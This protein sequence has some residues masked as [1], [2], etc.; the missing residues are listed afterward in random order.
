MH[1]PHTASAGN[2]GES[3]VPCYAP[4]VSSPP[5]PR[6]ETTQRIV[7]TGFMGS[8]KTTVGRLLAEQLGWQFADLDNRIE[9]GEGRTVPAIFAEQGEAAF[10]AAE[11]R[12]LREV[13]ALD[14][15][16][17][18]LGGGAAGTEANRHLLQRAAGTTIMHL[19]APFSVLFARCEAQARKP[20]A[21]ARPLLGEQAAAEQRYA[22]REPWYSALAHHQV[23]AGDAP[24]KVV[25]AILTLITPPLQSTK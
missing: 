12:A 20:G 16:V 7:L 15:V 6:R 19:D 24:E 9:V 4:P 1:L 23:K 21:T 22:Q 14:R 13:L 5:T 17:I 10:R 8:G 3:G 25:A 18:A 11:T 2:A